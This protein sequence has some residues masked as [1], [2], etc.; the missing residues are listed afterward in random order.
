MFRVQQLFNCLDLQKMVR[1]KRTQIFDKPGL[2]HC[3]VVVAILNLK[4]VPAIIRCSSGHRVIEKWV[5]GAEVG[6][7]G[8]KGR[9]LKGG[10]DGST[11]HTRL[12]PGRSTRPASATS[13]RTT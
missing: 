13:M 10:D 5:E 1:D 4:Q 2:V 12:F 7:V 6:G 9:I 11:A 8:G 3:W